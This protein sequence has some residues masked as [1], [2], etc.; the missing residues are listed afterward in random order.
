MPIE[1][2]TITIANGVCSRCNERNIGSEYAQ[3]VYGFKNN[4]ANL[5]KSDKMAEHAENVKVVG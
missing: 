4:G 1:R 3:P 5:V 2:L